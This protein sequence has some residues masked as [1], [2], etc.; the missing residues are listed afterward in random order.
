MATMSDS[1]LS[2]IKKQ[3][4]RCS[5]NLSD[6]MLQPEVLDQTDIEATGDQEDAI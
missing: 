5:T 4:M 6:M 3:F 2:T 1:V